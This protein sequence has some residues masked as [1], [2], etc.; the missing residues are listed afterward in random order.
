MVSPV[1]NRCLI[2][3]AF[4]LE[5]PR[6]FGSHPALFQKQT[7]MGESPCESLAIHCIRFVRQTHTS[8]CKLKAKFKA[9]VPLK[10]Y[11]SQPVEIRTAAQIPKSFARTDKLSAI[12]FFAVTK[13]WS[14]RVSGSGKTWARLHC[15]VDVG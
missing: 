9:S 5:L 11:A 7:P 3:K 10:V 13:F 14:L 15:K 2:E 4:L 6:T 1:G 12:T 8:T